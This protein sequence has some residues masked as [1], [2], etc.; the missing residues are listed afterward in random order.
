[1]DK[2]L[3]LTEEKTAVIEQVGEALAAFLTVA[4][5]DVSKESVK[6]MN[7]QLAAGKGYYRLTTEVSTTGLRV[8]SAFVT[9]QQHVVPIA[10]FYIGNSET[11]LSSEQATP[12]NLH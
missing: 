3:D 1:M 6:A 10:D 7:E 12:C 9:E 2:Q 4:L 8:F 5:R 11:E